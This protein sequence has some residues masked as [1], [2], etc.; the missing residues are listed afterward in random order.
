MRWLSN[1]FLNL[2]EIR[3][4]VLNITR[5]SLD[6]VFGNPPLADA[7]TPSKWVENFQLNPPD[8]ISLSHL[9]EIDRAYPFF[10]TVLLSNSGIIDLYTLLYDYTLNW[11]FR[12]L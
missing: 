6:A 4:S 3:F 2:S 12:G 5:R 10:T 7:T 1:M 11:S 8:K 9:A